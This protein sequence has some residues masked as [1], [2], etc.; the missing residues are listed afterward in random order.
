MQAIFLFL[1]FIDLYSFG[2]KKCI[3]L[4]LLLFLW[5]SLIAKGSEKQNV[6]L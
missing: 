4:L 3:F 2:T 5:F 1:I 6:G